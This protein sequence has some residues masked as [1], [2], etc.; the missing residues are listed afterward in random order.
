[1][2]SGYVGVLEEP[3]DSATLMPDLYV[4]AQFRHSKSL[5]RCFPESSSTSH[6]FEVSTHSEQQGTGLQ[7]ARQSIEPPHR[8]A[9]NA[10]EPDQKHFGSDGNISVSTHI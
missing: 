1:M 2:Q 4:R 5:I 7:H 3:I 9:K 10:V 6:A 8:G